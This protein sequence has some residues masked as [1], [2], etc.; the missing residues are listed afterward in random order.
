MPFLYDYTSKRSTIWAKQCLKECEE[1]HSSCERP[2]PVHVPSK[3]LHIYRSEREE[4]LLVSLCYTASSAHTDRGEI[5]Y[6]TLSYCW[7]GPQDFCLDATSEE[8]LLRG[9]S[10]TL[11]PKTI[12]DA[13]KV[14]FGLGISWIWIDSLCIRQDDTTEKAT[15]IA[16]M[17]QVYRNSSVT[18]S[19]T[20]ADSCRQGFLHPCSLPPLG[21]VSYRLPLALSTG[22]LGSVILS[23]T[24]EVTPIDRRS[25][26][27][28]EH[29][30]A[31]RVLRFTD[32][33]QHWSCGTTSKFESINPIYPPRAYKQG[34]ESIRELARRPKESHGLLN[35]VNGWM[36][37]VQQYTR[38][39][40]TI[41]SDKLLA[42]S[43]IAE[44][45]NPDSEDTYLAGVWE[46]HL[47]EGLLWACNDGRSHVPSATYVAPS[48]SWASISGSI[49][50]MVHIRCD[51]DPHI[52]IQDYFVELANDCAPYGAVKKGELIMRGLLQKTK[53]REAHSL[54]IPVE[55]SA[56]ELDLSLAY[57]AL[58]FYGET[59]MAKVAD[60]YL[61][62][63][64]ITVLHEED[65]DGPS[66]LIL[67]S[68]DN[69]EFSRIGMFTFFATDLD[70]DDFDAMTEED[71]ARQH[72][73]Q[74]AAFKNIIPRTF[75]L[76]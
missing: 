32:F 73:I 60:A 45:W 71:K 62:C 61:Y 14:A 26:T 35:H 74:I 66:G 65:M 31:R 75:C 16:Q 56:P 6:A 2:I 48:W 15:E 13:I 76:I 38:R 52:D 11:L 34:I 17:H 9:I 44:A 7:G 18:I 59:L 53:I 67:A 70:E 50:W 20:R 69:V 39:Q 47:P 24:N 10:V 25:W 12:I 8:K 37:I 42:I 29:L 28:Q 57:T 46:S 68:T 40:L 23:K 54:A 19:A 41:A 27:F 51:L 5:R 36:D 21:R 4:S 3:L 72:A 22:E 64:Q 55:E 49:N 1:S 43:A 58:D 30:L 63:F 33:G